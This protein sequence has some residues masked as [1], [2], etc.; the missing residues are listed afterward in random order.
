M[1]KQVVFSHVFD[2]GVH[3]NWN[4]KDLSLCAIFLHN[5]EE[6]HY[7]L[8]QTH[9]VYFIISCRGYH[10]IVLDVEWIYEAFQEK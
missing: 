2:S 6:A 4:V 9:I 3:I 8:Q 5:R 10:V 1:D 7:I